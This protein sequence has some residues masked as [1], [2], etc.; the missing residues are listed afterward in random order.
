MKLLNLITFIYATIFIINIYGQNFTS[1]KL[2]VSPGLNTHFRVTT[3]RIGDAAYICWENQYNSNYSIYVKKLFPQIQNTVTIAQDTCQLTN[4]TLTFLPNDD[5]QIVW[6]KYNNNHWQ[7][8][9]R[10]LIQ[11]SLGELIAIT[12]SISNNIEPAIY[13]KTLVWIHDSS[14][15]ISNQDSGWSNYEILDTLNCSNPDIIASENNRIYSIVYEKYNNAQSSLKEIVYLWGNYFNH[16]YADSGLNINPNY[17]WDSGLSYQKFEHEVW[18]I[19]VPGWDDGDWISSNLTFNMENPSLFSFIILTEDV[20]DYFVLYDSDT[21]SNNKEIY[22]KM[23]SEGASPFSNTIN[24][25]N[26]PGEDKKPFATVIDDSVTIFW[27][28]IISPDSSEIWWAKDY[29]NPPDPMGISGRTPS[30]ISLINNYPNPFNN[31]TNIEFS[32][33]QPDIVNVRIYD[34]RGKKIVELI[35]EMKKSGK[36]RVVWDGKNSINQTVASGVYIFTVSCGKLRQSKKIL[37]LK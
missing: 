1:K 32:L 25:S 12:D 11:D 19:V 21:L 33:N 15:V 8:F 14:L 17:G 5:I 27:E 20:S 31:T 13:F 18:K 36:H 3:H 4:P 37:F 10:C 35:N 2:I 28:H 29:F 34:N 6:Q 26:Q 22:V 30:Q 24:I 23:F 16:T 9:S 7:L